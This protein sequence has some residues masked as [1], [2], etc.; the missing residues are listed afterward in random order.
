M[1]SSS[2]VLTTLSVI[3]TAL[4][5]PC[6]L[7]WINWLAV[8]I[9]LT[10]AIVGIVGLATDKDPVTREVRDANVHL[11]A[12]ITGVVLTALGSLRCLLGGGCF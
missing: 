2:L 9:S 4:G 12:V 7:G 3:A 8:P 10:C 11:A 1:S 5:L 6:C